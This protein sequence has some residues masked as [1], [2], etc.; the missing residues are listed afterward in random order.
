MK[1]NHYQLLALILISFSSCTTM[2]YPNKVNMPLIAEK[3]DIEISLGHSEFDAQPGPRK[4]TELQSAYAFSKHFAGMANLS[5]GNTNEGASFYNYDQVE[6]AVG[7]YTRMGKHWRFNTFLGYGQLRSSGRT[8]DYNAEE[9]NA[10]FD[11]F[12]LQPGIAF[13]SK[14]FDISLAIRGFSVKEES[15]K[16]VDY[17]DYN[18]LTTRQESTSVQE[19]MGIEP[20]M[21]IQVG[22]DPIKFF[23]QGG[24]STYDMMY[25]GGAFASFGFVVSLPLKKKHNTNSDQL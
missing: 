9:R 19:Q 4:G 10:H 20:A 14:Y 24:F 17:T 7:F 23:M 2:Y 18:G 15:T 12:F 3:G 6:G 16:S 21:T 1:T 22:Y 5:F 11:K 25:T 8:V 13:A